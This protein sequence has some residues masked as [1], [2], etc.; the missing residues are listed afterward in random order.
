MLQTS[1]IAL[2]P[3]VLLLSIY[4]D[5]SLVLGN[6][7][8]AIQTQKTEFVLGKLNEFVEQ[9][10]PR[11]GLTKEDI[12]EALKESK[13]LDAKTLMYLKERDESRALFS[14]IAFAMKSFSGDLFEY[15]ER[16]E[17]YYKLFKS[18]GVSRQFEEILSPRENTID[19]LINSL[20]LEDEAKKKPLTT[21]LLYE[22]IVAYDGYNWN[23][24]SIGVSN[25]ENDVET[26]DW[27]LHFLSRDDV[28]ILHEEIFPLVKPEMNHD[29]LENLRKI[30]TDYMLRLGY[31]KRD[32]WYRDLDDSQNSHQ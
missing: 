32:T 17:F 11:S 9:N 18:R 29:E 13:I 4:G 31:A 16:L 26:I 7:V 25:N 22:G 15:V 27:I 30:F 8:E 5:S 24:Q 12:D 1:L 21:E 2:L 23:L 20:E 14:R 6:P 28:M 3:L 19:E 10:K